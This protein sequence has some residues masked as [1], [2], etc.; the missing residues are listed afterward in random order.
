MQDG[1]LDLEVDIG[2]TATDY[3]F[4]Q[5]DDPFLPRSTPGKGKGLTVIKDLAPLGS[6]QMNSNVNLSSSPKSQ[7]SVDGPN[8]LEVASKALGVRPSPVNASNHVSKTVHT[9]AMSVSSFRPGP[10]SSTI[11]NNAVK[12]IGAEYLR[13][14]QSTPFLEVTQRYEEASMVY[15]GIQQL[16]GDPSLLK[17]KVD[18]YVWSVK[19]YLAL[20]EAAAKRQRSDQV[21][22]EIHAQAEVIRQVESDF[23]EARERQKQLEEQD[24][25]ITK[26]INSLEVELKEAREIKSYLVGD[27]ATSG[28]S[29]ASLEDQVKVAK[30]SLDELESTPFVSA[31]E[32]SQLEEQKTHLQE[33]QS[34]IK[35][36]EWME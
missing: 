8:S 18:S 19:S 5:G 33:L 7:Q 27:L 22:R 26:K 13:L 29:L 35:P 16:R 6:A 14:L 15:K 32:I 11:F 21:E 17:R 24:V 23:A 25:A 20:E 31:E 4:A 30:Q 1:D 36:Y 34:M 3:L 9:H 28:T 12:L 2:N 10:N